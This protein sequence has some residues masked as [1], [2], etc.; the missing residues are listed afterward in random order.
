M[1]AH[2]KTS[3]DAWIKKEDSRGDIIFGADQQGKEVAFE[4]NI[5]S[6]WAR[7]GGARL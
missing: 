1:H 3:D 5:K 2:P 6:R 4:L 7:H